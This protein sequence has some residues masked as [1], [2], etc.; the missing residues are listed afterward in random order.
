MTY[1][2]ESSYLKYLIPTELANL[3]S[4]ILHAKAEYILII[5]AWAAE[6]VGINKTGHTLTVTLISDETT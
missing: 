3:K 1:Y 6:T 4:Q 2:P 5:R